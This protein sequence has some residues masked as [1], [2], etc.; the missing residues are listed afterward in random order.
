MAEMNPNQMTGVE[1]EALSPGQPPAE[2]A[3]STNDQPPQQ[4][5]MTAQQVEDLLN[6]QQQAMLEQS[7]RYMDTV[8]QVVQPQQPQV[9]QQPS[10]TMPTQEEVEDAFVSADGKKFMEIYTRSLQAVHA[11]NQQQIEALRVQGMARINELSDTVTEQTMPDWDRYKDAANEI[12]NEFNLDADLRSDPRVKK[13]MVEAAKGR[14]LDEEVNRAIEARNRQ[15]A[16]RPTADVRSGRQAETGEPDE[17]LFSQAALAA[18]RQAGRSPDRHAQQL[19]YENWE[20]FQKA[21]QEKYDTWE[22]RSVPAWRKRLNER[23]GAGRRR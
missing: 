4:G 18:L 20:A 3:T 13:L 11:A 7:Q 8:A 9:P 15:A 16:Q 14:N 1:D 23:R 10:V 22:E 6:R 17:P 12:M 5:F 19:G 2:Q 21:S